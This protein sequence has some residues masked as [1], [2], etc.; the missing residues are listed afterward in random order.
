MLFLLAPVINIEKA[1]AI[2]IPTYF[3]SIK[4]NYKNTQTQVSSSV[5]YH[6]LN[7]LM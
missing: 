5:N 4:N 2:I 3:L 7:T 6:K 1:S